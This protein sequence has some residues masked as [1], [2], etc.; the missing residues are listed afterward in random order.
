LSLAYVNGDILTAEEATVSIFDRGLAYGDGCFTTLRVSGGK[1]LLLEHH[2]ERLRRDAWALYIEPPPQ[3]EL[4][5]VCD[6]IIRH[7]PLAGGVVK[8][9]L[10]RGPAGRG[11]STRGATKTT[12][13][14]T[15]SE[16]PP[17]RGPIRAVTLPDDRGPLAIHKTLNYL[18]NVLALRKAEEA[19]CEEAIFGR[20]GSLIESVSSNL[21]GEVSGTLLTPPLDGRVLPGVIRRVLLESGAVEEGELPQDMEGPLYCVN[22]VRGVEAVRELDGRPLKRD[23]AIEKHLRAHSEPT[24]GVEPG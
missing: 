1:P 13:V 16:L 12:V 8:L 2:L 19:G 7:N 5:G 22:S 3:D 21:V 18:P 6:E 10:T 20:E 9:I 23:S 17:P 24:S 14:A 15:V 4:S 11:P